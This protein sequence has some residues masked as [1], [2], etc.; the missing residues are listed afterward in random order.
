MFID[1]VDIATSIFD[2]LLGIGDTKMN[3]SQFVPQSSIWFRRK[4][5]YKTSVHYD[6]KY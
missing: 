3:L 4:S 6:D 5:D 1:C 2:A